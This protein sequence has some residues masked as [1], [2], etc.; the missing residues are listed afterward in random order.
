MFFCPT[1]A[2]TQKIKLC[3]RDSEFF[4]EELP[5]KKKRS[6][7]VFSVFLQSRNTSLS[8]LNLVVKDE[9]AM[10]PIGPRVFELE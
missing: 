5:L 10:N 1:E 4:S 3:F 7:C 2:K 9:I 8:P 6:C